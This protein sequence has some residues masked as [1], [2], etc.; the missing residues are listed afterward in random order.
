MQ[1][2]LPQNDPVA[3]N[4]SVQG[5]ED[6][7]AGSSVQEDRDGVAN[8]EG[9]VQGIGGPASNTRSRRRGCNCCCGVHGSL[10]I[11]TV[12]HGGVYSARILVPC[13]MVVR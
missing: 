9:T 6:D 1:N 13:E 10:A 3:D 2:K 7:V 8:Q 12:N 4:S 11:H 5:D